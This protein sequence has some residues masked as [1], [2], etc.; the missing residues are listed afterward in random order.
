MVKI[1]VVSALISTWNKCKTIEF[2]QSE[3]VHIPTGSQDEECNNIS[4]KRML[5]L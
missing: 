5:L 1:L 3:C 2:F 4:T